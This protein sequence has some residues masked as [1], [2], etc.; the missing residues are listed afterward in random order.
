MIRVTDRQYF[1]HEA[2]ISN[3][4]SVVYN[5]KN[6]NWDFIILITADGMTRVGKSM[7]AQ[8]IGYFLA[9]ELET[10]FGMEN[11]VFGTHKLSE[12]ASKFPKNSLILLDEAREGMAS[13]RTMKEE[14]QNLMD[15]FAECGTYN[16]IYIVVLPDYFDLNKQFAVNRS[17][18]L[19]N[20]WVNRKD[21]E[22][23]HGNPISLWER[24]Y[25]DFYSKNKK[26]TLYNKH[27]KDYYYNSKLKDFTGYYDRYWIIDEQEYDAKKREF[28]KRSRESYAMNNKKLSIAL[29][30]LSQHK[31][32]KDIAA[33]MT[34]LKC[35]ITQARVSQLIKEADLYT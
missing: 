19:I 21:A 27:K 13:A 15:F 5:V 4:R 25:F 2:L 12:L 24:G 29:K 10:P 28:I 33:A 35:P 9:Q 22:D 26:K 11:I 14:Q 7:L 17:N 30:V 16:H 23:K 1:M 18:L 3:L 34:N 32:Q 20:C 8:Q 6:H 31:T